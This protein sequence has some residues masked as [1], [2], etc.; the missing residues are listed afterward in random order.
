M[1][2]SPKSPLASS[3]R[4]DLI[5][6]HLPLVRAIAR[7]Y[8]GRGEGLDD[9]IQVGAVGLIKAS[10]RYDPARGVSFAAFATPAIEGEIRRH[11]GDRTAPVRIPRAL[12]RLRSDL[13]WRRG[14]LTATLG[15]T[16]TVPELAAALAAE[17]RD[18]ERALVTEPSVGAGPVSPQEAAER[19][20]DAAALTGSEDRV[21]LTA[22]LRRLDARQRRIVFL[23]FHMDMTERQIASELGISQAHVSRL[24]A[25]ALAALRRDLGGSGGV[26]ISPP[27]SISGAR[28]VG[29]ETGGDGEQPVEN[30]ANIDKPHA[31]TT[32][33]AP[34]VPTRGIPGSAPAGQS[35][36]EESPPGAPDEP[37]VAAAPAPAPKGGPTRKGRF[38]VRMPPELHDQLA[39]AAEE[40]NVSLNRLVTDVLAG[41]IVAL[42]APETTDAA[43][44]IDAPETT[45]AADGGD[46]VATVG[47]GGAPAPA[48]DARAA[49]PAP[50][51][52]ALGVALAANLAIVVVAAAAAIVLLVL[53][54][55][56]GL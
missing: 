51:P 40:R 31:Q 8:G 41:A 19:I 14:E 9:L 34:V 7:R 55:H 21:L 30:D 4:S 47:E 12:Q 24:L 38:L 50:P 25:T 15:R 1:T 43:E 6:S 54:L 18:V 33:I 35:D 26:D 23:R 36:G 29:G 39:E 3:S 17:E 49:E 5:E 52:R 13:R 56:R 48:P 46:S 11:L 44:T 27:G 2:G 28:T 10:D 16:P 32:K 45:H 37:V 20:A 22:G 53:A 42:D